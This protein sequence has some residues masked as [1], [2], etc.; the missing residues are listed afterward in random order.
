MWKHG[1][2]FCSRAQ[3]KLRHLLMC[4][5]RNY[6]FIDSFPRSPQDSYLKVCSSQIVCL[7]FVPKSTEAQSIPL[8]E[9]P[10]FFKGCTENDGTHLSD[11]K[12]KNTSKLL[13]NC[14]GDEKKNLLPRRQK[15]YCWHIGQVK[16]WPTLLRCE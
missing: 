2:G 7:S 4:E 3:N 16:E 6:L 13:F 15:K 10:G 14:S 12:E 8:T 5:T 11:K 9:V 1:K